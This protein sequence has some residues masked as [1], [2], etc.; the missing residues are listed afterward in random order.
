MEHS[1]CISA[2]FSITMML[3]IGCGSYGGL[4]FTEENTFIDIESNQ[5]FRIAFT[6][7]G[8]VGRTCQ[9]ADKGDSTIISYLGSEY[10][11]IDGVA[12]GMGT[13][14]FLFE[15]IGFGNTEIV[16]QCTPSGME[17]I[18]YEIITFEVS[19]DF[20]PD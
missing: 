18:L 4:T 10:K 19:V 13:Q 11:S 16:V 1:K 14:Y 8:F 7:D 12:D 15:A 2:V 3:L 17:N 20:A 9:V 5:D 6:V